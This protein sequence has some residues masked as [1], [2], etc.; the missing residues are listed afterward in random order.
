VVDFVGKIYQEHFLSS[1]DFKCEFGLEIQSKKI[2]VAMEIG[3]KKVSVLGVEVTKE[4][5]LLRRG[6]Y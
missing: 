1:V 4:F 2:T 3:E 6:N 5:L